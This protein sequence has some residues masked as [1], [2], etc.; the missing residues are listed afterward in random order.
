MFAIMV[1]NAHITDEN[2]N[3]YAHCAVKIHIEISD[4]KL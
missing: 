3:I 1:E 2:V 4:H